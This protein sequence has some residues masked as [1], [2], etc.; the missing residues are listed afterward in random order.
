[1]QGKNGPC[2]VLA[3]INSVMVMQLMLKGQ[4]SP[5]YEPTDGDLAAAIAK[6]ISCSAS[7]V[8]DRKGSTCK[9]ATWAKEQS[10]NELAH[11]A[12]DFAEVQTGAALDAFCLKQV[13]AFKSVSDA[14]QT[15]PRMA[16]LYLTPNQAGGNPPRR[17][18]CRRDVW[19]RRCR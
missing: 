15:K 4:L 12:V 17:V 16:Y 1:M 5:A 9:V 8:E 11:P 18:L 14:H 3:L 13:E 2:G 6:V 19:R 7:Q 10:G